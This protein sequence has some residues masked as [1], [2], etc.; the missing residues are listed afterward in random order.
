[1]RP[2]SSHPTPAQHPIKIKSPIK[3]IFVL[4]FFFNFFRFFPTFYATLVLDMQSK[5]T[6]SK[7]YNENG[8]NFEH[9]TTHELYCP[10]LSFYVARNKK[11]MKITC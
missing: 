3:R 2:K 4:I 7:K 1:M 6:L 8:T 10:F 11:I 9:T 5:A